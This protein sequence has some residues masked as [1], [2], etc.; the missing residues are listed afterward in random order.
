MEI[1]NNNE[2][3]FSMNRFSQLVKYI[4]V[5][6]PILLLGSGLLGCTDPVRVGNNFL[7][8]PPSQGFI[9][10]SVFS[11]AT[12]AKEFLWHA[13]ESLPYGPGEVAG[14]YNKRKV[15]YDML[16]SLT[17]I[18]QSYLQIGG[19][20][21]TYYHPSGIPYSNNQTKYHYKNSGA[22]DGIRQAYIFIENVDKVPDMD[23]ATKK[24][25]KAEAR[26]IIALNYTQMIRHFGGL[27]WIDHAYRPSEDLKQ[28]RATIQATVDST[29]A[30][31]DKAI[32]DLPFTLDQPSTESGRFTQA[33]AMGLK[34]RL[35]LFAASPL[36]NSD[37]PYLDGEAADKKMVWY[38]GYH[39]NLWKRTADAAKTLI[40]KVEQTGAYHLV[41]TGNPRK[42]FRHGYYDRDSPEILISTRVRYRSPNGPG[43]CKYGCTYYYGSVLNGGAGATTDNYVR[44]FPM[45]NGDPITDPNSGYDPQHPYQN[46]DPRLYET[47]LV[48][49]DQYQGRTAELWIGGRERLQQDTRSTASGYRMRKFVLDGASAFGTVV[50]FPYLRLS[51]IYLSYAEALNEVNG[52]PTAEAYKYVNKVRNRVDLGD[53]PAGLSQKQFRADVIRE[54]ALELGYEEIRWYDL[55]RWKLK[56]DFTK[57]LYGMNI[58]KQSDGS[59]TYNRFEL[60]SRYWQN[61]WSP[62][63][64]L[65]AFPKD[66]VNMGYGLVQ[67]PGWE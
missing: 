38:G 36:F 45:A 56:D 44:M 22:W 18:N 65:S 37:R 61:N 51:E 32:P 53:L 35:L 33:G 55:I 6:I 40:D 47:V 11:S 21:K 60:P 39:P 24:R 25:L 57:K 54:R 27:P 63:W 58:R 5:V 8:K 13:Y 10:D 43:N 23:T 29:V 17:D 28:P 52:G 14:P 7:E 26:M 42:D 59:F 9:K 19:A 31:I 50:Q 48:N 64:Y 67:N 34:V 15:Q 62:K 30:M 4:L 2:A 1:L 12:R 20:R 3:H 49:G 66:E 16:A 46:R 41:D